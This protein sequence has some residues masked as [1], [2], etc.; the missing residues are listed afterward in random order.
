LNTDEKQKLK[1]EMMM[2]GYDDDSYDQEH[3]HN[4]QY[5]VED[6]ESSAV[7]GMTD[8]QIFKEQKKLFAA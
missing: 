7:Q 4:G 1:R 2:M 8:E 5:V 6:E 3:D